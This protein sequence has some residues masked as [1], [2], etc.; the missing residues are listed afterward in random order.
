[1][2][3]NGYQERKK[4]LPA[5]NVKVMYGG[6]QKKGVSMSKWLNN[7]TLLKVPRKKPKDKEEREWNSFYK[8]FQKD[9][10][11]KPCHYTG[12]CVYGQLI[13]EFPCHQTAEDFAIK[14]NKPR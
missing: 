14:M 1:M 8:E 11:M 10:H 13:E 7:K 3:I 4:L 12:F 9:D 5:R 2:D 6:N